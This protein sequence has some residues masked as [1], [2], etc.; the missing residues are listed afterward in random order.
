MNAIAHHHDP[1]LADTAPELA[2]IVHIADTIS[3]R[4]GIGLA[5]AIFLPKPSRQALLMLSLSQDEVDMLTGL[6]G[7][8]LLTSLG[9]LRGFI[10]TSGPHPNPLPKGEGASPFS[11]REKG[12]G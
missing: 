3:L 5:H 12:W 8:V 10:A 11:L 7:D 9:E 1:A 6:Y 4:L 2:A